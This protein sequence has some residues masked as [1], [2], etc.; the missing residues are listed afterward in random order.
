MDAIAVEIEPETEIVTLSD[1]ELDRNKPMPSKNH[2]I[3]QSNIGFEV[4]LNYREI[5]RVMSEVK[6]DVRSGK[7]IVPDLAIYPRFAFDPLHDEVKMTEMPLCAV[8]ILS[9]SQTNDEL[10]EKVVKYFSLGV[11]SCWLVI[12]TFQIVSVFSDASTQR[13]FF[14]GELHDEVLDIKIDLDKVFR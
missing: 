6:L 13:T 10:V 7:D 1:Y 5:Y 2:A 8:E 14:K 11:K 3:V 4:Q 12:P 9:P